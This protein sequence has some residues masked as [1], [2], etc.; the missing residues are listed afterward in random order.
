[1]HVMKGLHNHI[2]LVDIM[3]TLKL[4]PNSVCSL[5]RCSQEKPLIRNTATLGLGNQH[6]FTLE[7]SNLYFVIPYLKRE[8][9]RGLS[10]LRFQ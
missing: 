8:N 1:M 6:L 7:Y 10:K 4:D 5:R 2:F 3:L 9:L